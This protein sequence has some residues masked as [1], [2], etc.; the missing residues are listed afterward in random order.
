MS[1]TGKISLSGKDKTAKL[2]LWFISAVILIFC[3][4]GFAL[5]ADVTFNASVD[6][7]SVALDDTIQYTLAVSGNSVGSAP[8]PTLPKFTN[9]NVVGTYQ[10]SNISFINGKTSVSKSFVYTLQPEK[11]GPAHIGQASI[12]LG[13][14]TYTTE[15]IDIKVT[16][17]EGRKPQAGPP[18]GVRSRFP[19]MWDDFDEFFKS[20][21]PRFPRPEV[22]QDPV[23]VELKASQ[24]TVYVNQQIILTFT[25]Y[26]RVNLFQSPS[27]SPPDTTG[28]W[29]VN[30]PSDKD[31]REVTLNGIKYMAQDFKTALFP[32]TA[33]DFTIGPAT[34]LVQTD[35]FRAAQTIKTAPLKVKVLP[36]P[37]K[38]KPDNFSGA[39][40]SYQMDVT[41]KQPE[42]ERG[43]PVQITAKVW[44]S[45]NIQTISEPVSAFSADFKKLSSTGK[46]DMVKEKNGVSGYK[47][48]EI[49]LIPLKEGK[50][51]LP[52]FEFSYFDPDKKEYRTLK[53]RELSLT[54][55]PSEIPLPQE[56]EKSLAEDQAKKQMT[57]ITVDWQKI[58]AAILAVVTSVY[59][60]LPLSVLI[61]FMAIFI[62]YRKYQERL[63]ADP[64]KFRQKQALKVSRKRL[65]KASYL[66]KKNELKEFLGE[67]FNSVAKYLGDKYGFSANGITTDGLREILVNKGLSPDAQKKL[68]NFIYECDMLRF[69]PSSLSKEK[70]V[71]LAKVAE[72]LIITIE[73]K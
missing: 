10:S 15:P 4:S 25:F 46:E 21:S 57:T 43:Q 58:L 54:V 59:F 61:T 33:G 65:K 18:A 27:Y 38:G 14:Q 24:N 22:V 1:E 5:A 55:L 71:E 51:T 13:G 26:R 37:E 62:L 31:M 45:G 6:K 3:I 2:G 50:F 73:N 63:I 40:G 8:S 17:A 53:S 48:F 28:F 66:L 44:G 11:V 36:L 20:H 7:K 56:Y 34:L 42:I 23:K 41:L 32:T 47:S 68:D 9:L 70:A 30:L 19:G 67:I 60:W 49:V 29:A 72:N 35:P 64:A 69:T 12:N 52:S 16:K 39:V